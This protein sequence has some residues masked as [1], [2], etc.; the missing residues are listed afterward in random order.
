MEFITLF[1][2][3][4]N[5]SIVNLAEWFPQKSI[6]PVCIKNLIFNTYSL[7]HKGQC[8]QTRRFFLTFF[9]WNHSKNYSFIYL[10]IY[11]SISR[12]AIY[13][14]IYQIFR[15]HTYLFFI[16]C[17]YLLINL[18]YYK[19]DMRYVNTL[20][21]SWILSAIFIFLFLLSFFYCGRKL[22]NT[23]SLCTQSLHKSSTFGGNW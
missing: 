15:I 12:Q 17:T 16:V 22:C 7:I 11:L 13:V 5:N 4:V 3:E 8:K 6:Q 14:N 19:V 9:T 18:H 23:N 21:H 1:A 2:N 20:I 10:F